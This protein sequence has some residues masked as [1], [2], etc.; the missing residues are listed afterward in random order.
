MQI[1]AFDA[2][3]RRSSQCNLNAALHAQFALKFLDVLGE[4]QSKAP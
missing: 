1:V 3:I 4:L 2:K